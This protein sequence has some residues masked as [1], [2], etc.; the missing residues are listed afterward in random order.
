MRGNNPNH[1]WVRTPT[2]GGPVS[3][4]TR[5][6]PAWAVPASPPP[7][8]RAAG[9]APSVPVARSRTR[10]D[11]SEPHPHPHHHPQ[12]NPAELAPP[13]PPP[14]P[15]AEPAHAVSAALEPALVLTAAHSDTT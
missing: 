1:L 7:V 2:P 8:I 9:P 4:C 14:A 15:T 11:M 6:P 3:W 10:A 5:S 12:F 13:L